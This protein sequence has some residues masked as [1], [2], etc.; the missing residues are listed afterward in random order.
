MSKRKVVR[1][2]VYG[3]PDDESFSAETREPRRRV[4]GGVCQGD[5]AAPVRAGRRA[6]LA[7]D[8][9]PLG[10]SGAEGYVM[11]APKADTVG[12]AWAEH[13]S[14]AGWSNRLVWML[15][16]APGGK[17]RLDCLQPDEQSPLLQA[18]HAASAALSEELRA[19]VVRL[20]IP[21]RA[22]HSGHPSTRKACGGDSR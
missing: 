19:E 7:L 17:L 14:G 5:Q 13:C 22:Q 2:V 12:A 6:D 18:L 9:E 16:R 11:S 20:R 21:A 1:E 3:G 15:L 10:A 4:R 8:R